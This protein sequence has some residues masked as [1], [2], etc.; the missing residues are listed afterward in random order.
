MRR[1][2]RLYLRC[3]RVP[4]E[5]WV[6]VSK[7]TRISE[8]VICWMLVEHTKIYEDQHIVS[9]LNTNYFKYTSLNFEAKTRGKD[10]EMA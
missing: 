6:S 1:L 8:N 10:K 3:V 7:F 5:V 4:K 2:T 9:H